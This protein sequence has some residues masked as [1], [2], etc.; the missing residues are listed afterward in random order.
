MNDKPAE[1]RRIRP[2]GWRDPRLLIGLLLVAL[3]VT[4][5]V[6]LVQSI[7]ER[8]GYWAASTDI[9]PG[10]QVTAEDFHI[11][12]ASISES[13]E[14]YWEADTEL[15]PEFLVSSTI[16]QGELLTQRQVAQSDP[17]GRQQVGV[18]VSEDMPASVTIGSRV[19]VW[20]AAAREDGRGYEEPTKMISNAE[21][22]G[23]DNNTS[24]FAAANT[25]TVYMMLA[26]DA[27]PPVLDAQANDAKIALVP[28]TI[29][30]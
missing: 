24:A 22:T 10:A 25:T 1:A 23:T 4:G 2:P 3:S 28:A 30:D 21:V 15:P 26:Q 11:V 7:D 19:D 8:Q 17:D 18:R 6:A 13:A 20:V 27:V 29:G 16:L 14:H 12:Q 5:V 9:V